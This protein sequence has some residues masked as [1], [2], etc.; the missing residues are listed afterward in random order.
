M[1]ETQSKY[2][3]PFKS[4]ADGKHNFE[5]QVGKELF[6]AVEN[7]LVPDGNLVAKVE[8][9]KSE[10]MLKLHF[11][12]HGTVRATCDVCLDEFD[13]PIE[14]CEGDIVVK[15]GKDYEEISEELYV[16]P[17]SD[18][19]IS[20]AQWIYEFVCVTLPLRFEHSQAVGNQQCNPEMLE[21][22]SHYLVEEKTDSEETDT[23][24][25]DPRWEALKG[26]KS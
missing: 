16:I 1:I 22:L 21:R 9:N 17:E 19:D 7:A 5:W 3:I 10:Q 26:L 23:N 24:D 6:D 4:L 20:V 11:D 13:Y 18:T 15:F 25:I 2:V 14:D 12:I 8:M